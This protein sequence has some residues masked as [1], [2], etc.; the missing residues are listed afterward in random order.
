VFTFP[1]FTHILY[2]SL[3]AVN[4]VAILSEER[5]LARVGW[6]T[7]SLQQQAQSQGEPGGYGNGGTLKQR[8]VMLISA[9][10]TLMRLP[11]IPLNVLVILY[12]L[13]VR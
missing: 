11:L 2:A 9:V 6:S 7:S 1:I 5:F 12:E 13:V 3:L 4:S 10:R 8:T